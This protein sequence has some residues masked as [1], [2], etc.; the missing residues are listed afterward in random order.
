[1]IATLVLFFF[2]LWA[3]HTSPASQPEHTAAPP[4]TVN[5][6]TDPYAP[7]RLYDGKWDVQPASGDKQAEPVHIENHCAEVGEFFA[8]NQFVNGKNM[9]LVVFLPTHP[10]ENGGYAYRNQ[11]LRPESSDPS[12]WGNLEIVG[13]RWVYSSD[14]TDKGKK[15]YWRTTNVFFGRDKIHFEAQRSDDGVNWTTNLSGDEA[16]AK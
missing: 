2:T 16:R 8:C 7:L 11:A 15:I 10:L 12:F 14:E 6:A 4:K 1:V 5:L 9:A 13:D 3:S